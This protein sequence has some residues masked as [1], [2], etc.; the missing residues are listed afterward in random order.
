[1]KKKVGILGATGA[2]GQRLVA[3]LEN[4][5]WFE[6]AELCASDRSAG[7]RYGE[8]V[9]W[10]LPGPVPEKA[11]S[12]EIKE[13]RLPRLRLRLLGPLGRNGARGRA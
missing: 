6:V 12:L 7:G 2:V 10:K 8:R 1:M 9:R 4:H 3:M 11:A 13:C 5:P